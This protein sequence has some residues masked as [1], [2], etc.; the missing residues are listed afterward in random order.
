MTDTLVAQRKALWNTFCQECLK[1]GMKDPFNMIFRGLDG[2]DEIIY[3]HYLVPSLSQ[4]FEAYQ[5]ALDAYVATGVTLIEA[6]TEQIDRFTE[7]KQAAVAAGFEDEYAAV[8]D[9]LAYL[10]DEALQSYHAYLEAC[11]ASSTIWTRMAD[12]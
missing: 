5:A 11:N 1:L 3:Q 6:R 8:E 2:K 7:F 9:D 12:R 10:K 4:A